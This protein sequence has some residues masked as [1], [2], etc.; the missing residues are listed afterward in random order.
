MM[1]AV[2]TLLFAGYSQKNNGRRKFQ[3]AQNTGTLQAYGR[4]TGV[5]IRAG[6]RAGCVQSVTVARIVVACDQDDAF[7]IFG[8]ATLEDR[9]NISDYGGLWDAIGGA[10]GEAVG[11]YLE[12]SVAI[13]RVTFKLVLD[14]LSRYAD[15]TTC[16]DRGLILRGKS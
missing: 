4:A 1:A 6:S 12:T 10:L 9:I 7:S 8:I 13:A 5:I 3:L 14:P 15:A 2:Q 16:H 11:L